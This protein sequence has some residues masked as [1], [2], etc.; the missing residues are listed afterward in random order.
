[1]HT[2]MG[3]APNGGAASD[4]RFPLGT[5]LA[6]GALAVAAHAAP[7]APFLLDGRALMETRR[8][9]TAG[10]PALAAGVKEL[11]ARAERQMR[12][13]LWTVTSKPFA[14][15]SGD[16]HDYVSLASYFWPDPQR[17]DG[18]PYVSRDG[19]LN[20]ETRE[21][22]RTRLDGMCEAVHS[23]ALAWYLTGE[24]P[25]GRRAV[26]QLRAWFLDEATRMNPHLT[27]A[28]MVKGKNEGNPWGLIETERLTQV[29]DAVALLRTGPDWTAGDQ[30]GLEQWFSQYLDWLQTSDLGQRERAAP[31]N[32][33][34][35]YDVQT[36][37]FALFLGRTEL[38][39]DILEGVKTNRI[40]RQIEPDGSQPAEL[41]RTKSWSYTLLNLEGLF[42]LG[43]LGDQVGVDLWHYR[44]TDGRGIRA[45]L[46]WLMPYIDG[47]PWERQ[48]LTRQAREP[49]VWILRR[50][51]VAYAEPAYEQRI[52]RLPGVERQLAWMELLSPAPEARPAGAGTSTGVGGVP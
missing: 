47:K 11:R 39:R 25:Y 50:A 17:T 37:V 13:E 20:P 24:E 32:H 18:L 6:A 9:V 33:G 8:R 29:V 31:N 26:T 36:S 35:L 14:G 5:C 23:L 4:R 45:A 16:K 38:A 44:T 10:D 7:P 40:A 42:R 27:N 46:E 30:K 19:E 43:H 1:M 28:Q 52:R 51:A 12:A 48:Q 2:Q 41:K 34:T 49:L 15:P 22:D 21:Y 3:C